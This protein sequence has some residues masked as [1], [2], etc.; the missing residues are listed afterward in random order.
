MLCVFL[1]RDALKQSHALQYARHTIWCTH[2]YHAAEHITGA[3]PCGDDDDDDDTDFTQSQR[4]RTIFSQCC[5]L[6]P[7]RV[8]VFWCSVVYV[9]WGV[10]GVVS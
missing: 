3:E 8:A 5:W 2:T 1:P 6:C 10:G 4:T 7:L 9:G